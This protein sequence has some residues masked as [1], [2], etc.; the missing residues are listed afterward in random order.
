VGYIEQELIGLHQL[1]AGHLVPVGRVLAQER[2]R[3]RLNGVIGRLIADQAKARNSIGE[4]QLDI[5]ELSHKFQEETAASILEVRQ[6]IADLR[7]K[8]SVTADITHRIDITAPVSGTVQ[9]LKVYAVGSGHPAGEQLMEV[10][11]DEEKLVVH[12][13]FQPVDIDRVHRAREVECAVSVV[14]TPERPGH[15]RL[16]RIRFGRAG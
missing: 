8:V 9:G 14:P 15:S 2:E 12:A 4:T 5:Q 11:P 16:S 6:R 13:Q 1:L 7:E 3:S 10:V